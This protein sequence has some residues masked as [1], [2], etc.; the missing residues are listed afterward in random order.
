[1]K[2]FTASA[3]C[4]LLFIVL[5]TSLF[6]AR[7]PSESAVRVIEKFNA[8]L[9]E[10]MKRGDELGYSGRYALLEP[11]MK[12]YFFYSLMVRK[13]TGSYWKTMNAEQQQLL[14][15]K[16]I[17]WSVGSYADRF[18]RHKGQQFTVVSSKQVRKKYMQ[19]NVRII[20][21]D[22]RKRHLEYLLI[23]DKGVWRII[24]I[25]V[26]G[27]SQLSLTRA[28]FK[29]VLKKQGIDGLLKVLDEKIN[30]LNRA[31]SG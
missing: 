13:S 25:K 11:F 24:D 12:K 8:T 9:L 31:G 26:K 2:K 20:K 3:L 19:V 17:T 23:E 29:S 4:S 10:C 22:K 14:L 5:S 7:V 16:Y 18:T 15:K 30:T 6:A 1:M 28:Q 27:V 21:A